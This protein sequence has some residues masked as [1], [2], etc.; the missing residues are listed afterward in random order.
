MSFQPVPDGIQITMN[1]VSNLGTVA[2]NRYFVSD[3]T[4]PSPTN[5][6]LATETF[7]TWWAENL[8]AA[9][10]ASWTLNNITGRGMDTEFGLEIINTTDLP[11]AGS[12]T[13]AAAAFQV[14]ATITW[15]TGLVGRSFRGR[16]YFVGM[17]AA[18]ALGNHLDSSFQ[19]GIQTAFD[20]L[21]ELLDTAGFELGVVSFVSAGVPRT[22][23]L[24]T[25]VTSARVNSQV[26]TQ[27][28]RLS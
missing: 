15:L 11:E 18:Q 17:A 20:A 9:T 1:Y 8:R 13:G 21:L 3:G 22:D 23:G 5:I 26:H 24:F 19:A 7:N 12:G 14:S 2:Q 4:S 6:E 16:T 25:P 10:N 27:R 28:R